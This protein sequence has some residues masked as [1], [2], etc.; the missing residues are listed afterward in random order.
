MEEKPTDTRNDG[1]EEALKS[2]ESLGT[3]LDM[4]KEPTP[5]D[6]SDEQPKP[7]ENGSVAEAGDGLKGPEPV[8]SE[9]EVIVTK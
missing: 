2:P 7:L 3:A 4:I 8:V 1:T 5:I 9:S 6:Q